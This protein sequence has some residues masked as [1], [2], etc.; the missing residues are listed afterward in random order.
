MKKIFENIN[1]VKKYGKNF[2][3]GCK[4]RLFFTAFNCFLEPISNKLCLIS[5]DWIN[6]FEKNFHSDYILRSK[7]HSCKNDCYSTI[8]QEADFFLLHFS[9][10]FFNLF[11]F[12]LV[13]NIP[14]IDIFSTSTKSQSNS[15][16]IKSYIFFLSTA[17]Y[18]E[19]DFSVD[20]YLR[21]K[22]NEWK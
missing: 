7:N 5:F 18:F 19:T 16:S 10:S 15:N 1:S 21:N 3:A 2:L 8:L 12:F 9:S 22:P 4:K 13:D 14:L 17:N 20:F 6:I 11:E